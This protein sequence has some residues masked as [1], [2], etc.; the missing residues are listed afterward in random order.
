MGYFVEKLIPITNWYFKQIHLGVWIVESN[1]DRDISRC[2]FQTIKIETLDW[3]W[4]KNWDLRA[5]RLPRCIFSKSREFHNCRDWLQKDFEIESLDQEHVNTN[6]YKLI[7][8]DTNRYKL[9]QIN[10]IRFKSI[11]INTNQAYLT[12]IRC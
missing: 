7:Q 10:T 12:Y 8:I 1:R 3:D 9:I 4:A 2:P 11:Q 6:W 5:S